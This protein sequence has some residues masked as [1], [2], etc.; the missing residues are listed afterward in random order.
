MQGLIF[1]IKRF[2][3]HDGP[4]IRTTVFFKGCPLSCWWCHNPESRRA[5][6]EKITVEHPLNGKSIQST[7]IVGRLMTVAEVMT[8]LEKEKVFMEESGGGVTFSGGEPLQQPGFLT[9]LA[10]HCREAGIHTTLDTSGYAG[11][12][13]LEA[14]LPFTNLFLYDLKLLDDHLHRKYTGVSNKQILENL[15]FL[16]VQGA[17]IR[18]RYPL[19]PGINDAPEQLGALATFLEKLPRPVEGIDILP[20]H[21]LAA[22]KYEKFGFKY[23]M[24]GYHEPSADEVNSA[25]EFFEQRGVAT[26][27][28]G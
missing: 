13:E 20:Y 9:E 15:F 10:W 23:R 16:S 18:I 17:E 22:H 6:L 24:K 11:R 4:G 12:A 25:Q 3:V 28:G 26:G 8:E 2:A 5:T 7:E 21:A 14:V 19:I 27:I 1:D